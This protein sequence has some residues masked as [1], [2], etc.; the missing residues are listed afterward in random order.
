M[1]EAFTASGSSGEQENPAQVPGVV[2]KLMAARVSERNGDPQGASL[3]SNFSLD[4]LLATLS[5]CDVNTEQSL[6][7]VLFRGDH[8][9]LHVEDGLYIRL[10]WVDLVFEQIES[11]CEYESALL[12]QLLKFRLPL[13]RLA[14]VD[15]SL[16]NDSNH[17]VR[18]FFSMVS[19]LAVGWTSNSAG[20]GRKLFDAV[21]AVQA[22]I[23]PIG[24]EEKTKIFDSFNIGATKINDLA[25]L[26]NRFERR[27]CE[28]KVGELRAAKADLLV[29]SFLNKVMGGKRIPTVV[30]NFV[31]GPWRQSMR[32]TYLKCGNRSIE[33]T[34]ISKL[35]VILISS[36]V[37]QSDADRKRLYRIIPKLPNQ[38]KQHLGGLVNAEM[39]TQQ[40]LDSLDDVYVSL[41]KKEKIET[42]EMEMLKPMGN[43]Q[44]VE[45]SVSK[46][47]NR[48]LSVLRVGQWYKYT[49][50]DGEV[51][52]LRLAMKMEDI[53][54]LLFV[55]IEG[56][57]AL[58]KSFE[59]VA[60]YLT[61]KLMVS[62]D[63]N[64]FF[65]LACQRVDRLILEPLEIRSLDVES[66]QL[67]KAKPSEKENK[68]E[69]IKENENSKSKKVESVEE[70]ISHDPNENE[71]EN[72][73]ENERLEIS[74]S[75]S[76]PPVSTTA[77]KSLERKTV[78]QKEA[79]LEAKVAKVWALRTEYVSRN[80][81]H[82][83]VQKAKVIIDSLVIGS[84]INYI[85]ESNVK[86]R[87][88]LAVK[89]RST[90]KLIFVDREGVK[91]LVCRSDYLIAKYVVDEVT[92]LDSGPMFE[93]ALEKVVGGLRTSR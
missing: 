86:K 64:S 35:T 42:V 51:L 17:P 48:K 78:E 59:S 16:V 75:D 87:C 6:L 54:Q 31:L 73:N 7:E 80:K 41:L 28:V 36:V 85:D 49:L 81:Q 32:A 60:Y 25:V 43:Q 45:V 71:D 89:L 34:E 12:S 5:A 67:K 76:V 30:V 72:E 23:Y 37:A 10:Q 79:E 61:L 68:K 40:F 24:V 14:M 8:Y 33:W 46:R 18:V 57:N 47:L 66:R 69:E 65:E 63:K 26:A 77:P 21:Q 93:S 3:D 55:N 9:P 91:V 58:N 1:S 92:I 11:A 88:K 22:E 38:I 27:V 13:G 84:W 83:A 82:G 15:E 19:I 4:S 44:F 74:S 90:D 70:Q 50:E 53:S 62:L 56:R 52:R 29:T 2:A 39:T 20:V